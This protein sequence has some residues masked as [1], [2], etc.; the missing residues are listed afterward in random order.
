[1]QWRSPDQNCVPTITAMHC[2]MTCTTI[3]Y[4]SPRRP[5]A[6]SVAS[7]DRGGRNVAFTAACRLPIATEIAVEMTLGLDW[8]RNMLRW[9]PSSCVIQSESDSRSWGCLCDP[10]WRL[11]FSL[12]TPKV[13]D[14]LAA[15]Y[16]IGC[17]WDDHF[18]R[19]IPQFSICR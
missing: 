3:R 16:P 4:H 18:F 6:E 10:S 13:I 2:I 7:N 1:M 19:R 5:A 15:T 9:C 8:T 14:V 11:A 17:K 12:L